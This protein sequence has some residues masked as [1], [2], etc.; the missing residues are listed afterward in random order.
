ML[1]WLDPAFDSG[2]I[3]FSGVFQ[4]QASLPASSNSWIQNLTTSL[5]CLSLCTVSNRPVLPALLLPDAALS[6]NK[7]YTIENANGTTHTALLQR[8]CICSGREYAEK[9]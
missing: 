3:T 7:R 5:A 9:H 4:A 2:F 8:I 6:L 1:H